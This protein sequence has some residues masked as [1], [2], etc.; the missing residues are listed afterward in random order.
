M[1]EELAKHQMSVAV[2]LDM[3]DQIVKILFAIMYLI[4]VLMFVVE[5]VL[6][7]HLIPATVIADM[8]IRNV[9]S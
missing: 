1:E 3:V 7:Q 2:V 6:A 4:Q 5:M 9:T 8:V